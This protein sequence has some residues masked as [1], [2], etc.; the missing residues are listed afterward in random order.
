MPSG[1]PVLD[2]PPVVDE[3]THTSAPPPLDAPASPAPSPSPSPDGT[4]GGTA[5]SPEPD[6]A[7][8]DSWPAWQ[9]AIIALAGL[10][11][12]LLIGVVIGARLTDDDDTDGAA[13]VEG[14]AAEPVEVG[15]THDIG[16]GWALRVVDVDIDSGD[17]IARLRDA[18]EPPGPNETYLLVTLQLAYTADAGEPLVGQPQHVLL[19]LV[20]ENGT[21]YLAHQRSCGLFPNAIF[22]YPAVPPGEAITANQ[23]W[24]VP[25]DKLDGMVLVVATRRLTSHFALR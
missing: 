2:E 12:G 6:A 5:A 23:C 18:N 13:P 21:E 1:P 20:D 10:L 9:L 3:S 14:S 17:E 22:N 24:A 7:A 16:S 4:L 15:A 19:S 11:V 25:T 8:N